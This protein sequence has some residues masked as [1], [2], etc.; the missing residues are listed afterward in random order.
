MKNL[1]YF[2]I[3]AILAL[4]SHSLPAQAPQFYNYQI[5]ENTNYYPFGV[6]AGKGVQWLYTPGN[7]NQPAPVTSGVI[8]KV[9]FFMGYTN[10]NATLYNLC[11]KLGQ[12]AIT[13]LPSGVLYTGPL[14]TVYFRSTVNLTSNVGQWMGITLDYP[15]V[16]DSSQTLIVDVSQYGATNTTLVV[17]QHTYTGIKR[18]Y[19]NT[20][21]YVYN[22]QDAYAVNFGFDLAPSLPQ[23]PPYYNYNNGTNN[24]T[25]PFAQTGGQRVNW[26]ITAGTLN[27]P[28]C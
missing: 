17:C 22:G 25:Y 26:L 28:R 8:T 4:S 23:T 11:I 24:N 21:P 1:F 5:L 20:Y 10:G 18:T 9:Y 6:A 27:K 12:S 7:F 16:Y 3:S 19:Y 2:V 15:F 13:N 14:D